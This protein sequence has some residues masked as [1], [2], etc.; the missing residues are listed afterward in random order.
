MS[1][2]ETLTPGD[3]AAVRKRFDRAREVTAA[4]FREA[5]AAQPATIAANER[6]RMHL[7]LQARALLEQL[8]E[9]TIPP[10]HELHYVISEERGRW[11]APIVVAAEGIDPAGAATG[12]PQD[13]RTGLFPFFRIGRSGVALLEY[14]M[15]I[16]ELLGST[17][18]RMTKL[19][20]SSAE[21]DE[22]I[23]RMEQPQF[24]RALFLEFLPSYEWRANETALLELTLYSRAGEERIER[25]HLMLDEA[26][27]FQFHSRDVA[28][29]GRGGIR[30]DA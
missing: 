9:V 24:V 29:E 25:R 14:W 11:I 22:A 3:V 18:S 16:T 30:V 15:L 13:P 12:N 17:E 21:Y 1:V 2:M 5:F 20:A 8:S 27:E 26:Q 4:R 23:G 28:V 6:W 19:V 10:D 7:E